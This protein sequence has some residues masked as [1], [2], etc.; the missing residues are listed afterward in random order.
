M[1]KWPRGP[2]DLDALPVILKLLEVELRPE[3]WVALEAWCREQRAPLQDSKPGPI[4]VARSA[5]H[6]G[7]AL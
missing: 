1:A 4:L 3:D 2:V 5:R 7:G 6:R